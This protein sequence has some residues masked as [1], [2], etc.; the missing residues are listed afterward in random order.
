MSDFIEGIA[1]KT[2]ERAENFLR[3]SI[4]EFFKIEFKCGS[5]KEIE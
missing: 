5:K 2:S 1:A 3:K 4:F